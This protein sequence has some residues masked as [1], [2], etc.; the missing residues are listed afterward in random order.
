MEKRTKNTTM[1]TKKASRPVKFVLTRVAMFGLTLGVFVWLWAPVA[2]A[3]RPETPADDNTPDESA[4]SE[5]AGDSDPAEEWVWDESKRDW[6]LASELSVTA[7]EEQG[8]TAK[9][10]EHVVIVERQPVHYVYKYIH[11][12][13]VPVYVVITATSQSATVPAVADAP[14]PTPPA[15]ADAPSGA[16]SPPSSTA[17]P[18]PQSPQPPTPTTPALRETAGMLGTTVDGVKGR[19]ARALATLRERMSKSGPETGGTAKQER[20]RSRAS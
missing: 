16:A 5:E 14:A 2:W 13:P 20:D 12:T 15:A 8:E 3:N 10:P 4:Q 9:Q 19:Q 6:V 1:T 11:E 17:A 7:A 18:K